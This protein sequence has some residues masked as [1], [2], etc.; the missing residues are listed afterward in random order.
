MTKKVELLVVDDQIGVRR[1]L[2]EAFRQDDYNVELAG[3]GL[4]AIDK[5]KQKKPDVILMDMKMPGMNG[6]ETLK[7]IKKLDFNP[8]IIMMT[9]YGEV[10]IVS[11][12]MNLG[13]KE[14]VTK[15]FDINELREMVKKVVENSEKAS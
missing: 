14:Y 15:P 2:F 11:E 4:E 13:V 9:A 7:E 12:A 10:D 8:N 5:I 1:L 3:S 6:L